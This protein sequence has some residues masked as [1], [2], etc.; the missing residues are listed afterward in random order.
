MKGYL[1]VPN[2]VSS[3]LG[4]YKS[5]KVPI[6]F[7]GH[8]FYLDAIQLEAKEKATRNKSKTFLGHTGELSLSASLESKVKQLTTIETQGLY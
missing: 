2:T 4:G 5:A 6:T 8:S 7:G 1:D 3:L